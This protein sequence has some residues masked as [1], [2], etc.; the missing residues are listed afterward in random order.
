MSQL[1]RSFFPLCCIVSLAW[2]SISFLVI[3]APTSHIVAYLFPFLNGSV[4]LRRFFH[5]SPFVFL[6]DL[7]PPPTDLAPL[8][9]LCHTP[10]PHPPTD[11]SFIVCSAFLFIFF[12]QCASDECPPPC[13]PSSFTFVFFIPYVF[14]WV[15]IGRLH[16]PKFFS[17][18][19]FL[20]PPRTPLPLD[21][22]CF[23]LFVPTFS[24]RVT[25]ALFAFSFFLC[26]V[27]Y[28]PVARYLFCFYFI[29]HPP[30]LSDFA[31]TRVS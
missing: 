12:L 21:Y 22:C 8:S 23:C 20:I 30:T 26:L 25:L 10:F 14:F 18:F 5:A 3:L 28:S 27:R 2:D 7:S 19:I 6:S 15:F 9:T 29:L 31:L 4:P 13:L 16:F 11:C 1:V 24:R 17:F